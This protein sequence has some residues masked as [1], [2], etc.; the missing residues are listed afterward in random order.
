MIEIEILWVTKQ[1]IF[2]RARKSP[3][4]KI[5]V[6]WKNELYS[7]PLL[8]LAFLEALL[9]TDP[10]TRWSRV[11]NASA[12]FAFSLVTQ[13][14]SGWNIMSSSSSGLKS[15]WQC[16]YGNCFVFWKAQHQEEAVRLSPPEHPTLS[17]FTLQGGQVST[18]TL[19]HLKTTKLQ[20]QLSQNLRNRE[21]ILMAAHQ[22]ITLANTAKIN[23]GFFSSQFFN[24]FQRQH[25]DPH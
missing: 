1:K 10:W 15:H 17:V 7:C 12:S 9:G 11:W 8:I 25:V 13:K 18:S 5:F 2:T 20:L 22:V 6:G 16:S 3:E 23:S 21:I 19:R 14:N 4:L 24:V